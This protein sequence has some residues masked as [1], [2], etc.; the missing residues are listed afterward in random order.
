M[1]TDGNP[2]EFEEL[3]HS[4]K[5]KT[6]V[7]TARRLSEL[8]RGIRDLGGTL[9]VKKRADTLAR[10]ME[11]AIKRLG[12]RSQESEVR[13][14]DKKVLFI[15]WPEPLI[16]AG[17]GT[18]MDDAVRLLGYENI[19]GS[20]KAA[21]PKYSIEEVIREAPDFLFIG[22]G[23]GMDMRTVSQGILKKMTSVPAVK[24]GAVFYVSDNLYRLGPR[25]VAGIEE[26]A[27]CLK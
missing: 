4:L 20:A 6:Y 22:K 23:S 9:G 14:R 18:V 24:N 11:V 17:P 12:V 1:T 26:L 8:P 13:R 19:A 21:Y 7:F 16:V 10:E 25:V 3:L 15:V 2:K 5:V 27:A